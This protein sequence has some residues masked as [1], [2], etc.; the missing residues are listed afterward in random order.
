MQNNILLPN[1]NI[2]PLTGMS[3]SQGA[4]PADIN[5]N[6]PEND[7][8]FQDSGFK[9]GLINIGRKVGLVSR[10]PS[11]S[12]SPLEEHPILQPSVSRP[13]G[14][15]RSNSYPNDNQEYIPPESQ[16]MASMTTQALK[17]DQEDARIRRAS[18]QG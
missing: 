8:H 15:F 6:I 14:S 12:Q 5:H 18:M 7:P 2:A 16:L 4:K 13:K 11:V 17:K 9:K 1:S 3:R 10:K